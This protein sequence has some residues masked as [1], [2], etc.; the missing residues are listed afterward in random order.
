[1]SREYTPSDKKFLPSELV[2]IYT[3]VRSKIQPNYKY[4]G[5]LTV[6][7]GELRRLLLENHIYA[8]HYMQWIWNYHAKYR[9][10]VYISMVSSA[11]SVQLYMKTAAYTEKDRETELHIKLD[12]QKEVIQTELKRGRKLRDILMD[13][14]LVIGVVMR[15]ALAH[16][17][18]LEDLVHSFCSE[19]E[20]EIIYE[21]LYIKLIGDYLPP[22]IGMQN[23]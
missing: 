12:I 2:D 9:S 16:S 10:L 5:D 11:T 6:D 14:S 23:G 3:T 7:W 8:P 15:Y 19:A 20:H 17:G 4:I 1:V 13:E 18:G 22:G 21:P